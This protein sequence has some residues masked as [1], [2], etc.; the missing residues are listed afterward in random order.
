MI[1]RTEIAR[2]REINIDIFKN[3]SLHYIPM[4]LQFY[5]FLSL[6]NSVCLYDIKYQLYT[7]WG[8]TK[9]EKSWQWLFLTDIKSK[10]AVI[11]WLFLVSTDG[12]DKMI[13]ILIY[14]FNKYI[15]DNIWKNK[16]NFKI[17]FSH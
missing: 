10:N 17:C 3:T 13:C 6:Q 4:Q 11:Y 8:E 9:K 14:Y 1:D 12:F 16:M 7:T 2:E 15:L 5:T